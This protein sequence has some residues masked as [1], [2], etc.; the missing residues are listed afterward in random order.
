M[1]QKRGEGEARAEA[2]TEVASYGLI[3]HP[4]KSYWLLPGVTG[5]K[6][7]PLIRQDQKIRCAFPVGGVC[8]ISSSG[9][10][11]NGSR[12]ELWIPDR[13]DFLSRAML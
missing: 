9:I 13:E 8:H 12:D 7:P 11:S 10:N 4:A 3:T 6:C 5:M 2:G 1:L